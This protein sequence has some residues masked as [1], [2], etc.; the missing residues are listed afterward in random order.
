MKRVIFILTIISSFLIYSCS[1][2]SD[3]KEDKDEKTKTEVKEVKKEI[4]SKL[5]E[6]KTKVSKNECDEFLKKY[7]KWA[8]EYIKIYKKSKK[9]PTDMSVITEMTKL[10]TEALTWLEK[11]QAIETCTKDPVY[12]KRYAEIAK[13]IEAATK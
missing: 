5:I 3:K 10:A 1:G 2:D 4:D 7:D 9:N 6:N 12:A 8:D 13:K 11:W